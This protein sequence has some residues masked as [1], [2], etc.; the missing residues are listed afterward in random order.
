[1]RH[2]RFTVAIVGLALFAAAC[3][4][5]SGSGQGSVAATEA[6]APEARVTAAQDALTKAQSDLVAANES[7]CTE[8]TDYVT[9]IDRYGKL[10]TDSKATV[11]DIKTVGADL[12]APRDSVSA[13]ADAVGAAQD[14]VVAAEQELADAQAALANAQASAAGQPATA[15]AAP[16]SPT[17]TVVPPA[18]INRVTQAEADLEDAATGITDQTPLVEATVEYHSA[19]FALEVVWLKLLADAGCLSD[20]QQAQAVAQVTEYTIVLQT[21]LE[22]GGYYT[23]AIDGIYGPL[24]VEAVKQLQTDKGLPVTGLVDMATALALEKDAA[25]QAVTQTIVL[26][27]VLKLTGFWEGE[28]DGKWTP[29]LTDALKAFQTE[30]GVEP[31]GAVDVAT[32]AAFQEALA[33]LQ[34]SATS[35]TTTAAAQTTGAPGSTAA[36]TT[37]ASVPTT[38]APPATT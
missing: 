15:T 10:F 21:Q 6:A 2:L 26:Q 5:D 17:T 33:A 37:A 28:I 13:A 20:E 36:P 16:P 34:G 22:A 14:A 12:G 31:T 23:A 27:T 35:S 25:A 30:L 32:L 1:M 7:F 19:A 3:G 18:T 9:A 24:T 29:E 11:G 8:A 38:A 4:D